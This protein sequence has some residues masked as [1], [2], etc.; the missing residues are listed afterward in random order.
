MHELTNKTNLTHTQVHH[1]IRWQM[2]LENVQ[3]INEVHLNVLETEQWI[4]D[5]EENSSRKR[6]WKEIP[7]DGFILE[8]CSNGKSNV[9]KYWHYE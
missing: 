5:I 8:N 6:C 2:D 9:G 7:V 3:P 1:K 4:L